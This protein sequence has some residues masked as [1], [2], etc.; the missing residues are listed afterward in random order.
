LRYYHY[1]RKEA[2]NGDVYIPP[3]NFKMAHE[4]EDSDFEDLEA[5]DESPGDESMYDLFSRLDISLSIKECYE[6][7][8]KFPAE[9]VSHLDNEEYFTSCANSAIELVKIGHHPCFLDLDRR[10]YLKTTWPLVFRLHNGSISGNS[11]HRLIVG[12]KGTGKSSFL[13][14]I[15][16]C[17]QKMLP[18]VVAVFLDFNDIIKSPNPQDA[19]GYIFD[20]L[21]ACHMID[22]SEAG[23]GTF[24]HLLELLLEKKIKVYL[25]V[26]EYHAVYAITDQWGKDF[27]LSIY[28]MVND[29]SGHFAVTVC[30]SSAYL[31]AL[32]FGKLN[33]S[34]ENFPAYIAGACSLNSSRTGVS[35]LGPIV[36][37]YEFRRYV[38][39][40]PSLCRHASGEKDVEVLFLL[41]G[42]VRRTVDNLASTPEGVWADEYRCCEEHKLCKTWGAVWL[43][44]IVQIRHKKHLQG[45]IAMTETNISPWEYMEWIDCDDI[46]SLIRSKEDPFSQFFKK[47]DVSGD[48]LD[49]GLV[50]VSDIDFSDLRRF[51]RG[52]DEGAFVFQLTKHGSR[53]RF[54]V[55]Y[56]FEFM[57]RRTWNS[58]VCPTWF[59]PYYQLCM[60]Y[61]Y[62]VLGIDAEA[63][64]AHCLAAQVYPLGYDTG[65]DIV[66]NINVS[67]IDSKKRDKIKAINVQWDTAIEKLTLAWID[68]F[69]QPAVFKEIP[70]WLGSDLVVVK[71]KLEDRYQV[72]LGKSPLLPRD[73]RDIMARFDSGIALK[74]T[75]YKRK[76]PKRF[77]KFLITSREMQISTEKNLTDGGVSV[78]KVYQLLVPELISWAR[79]LGLMHYL[80]TGD[81]LPPSV[82]PSMHV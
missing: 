33:G 7:A 2:T 66:G 15:C 43:A 71:D 59:T 79:S 34:V 19:S 49:N 81:V 51:F 76:T 64:I 4:N 23:D 9:I 37:R 60:S 62:G 73:A 20:A 40:Y 75:F 22:A 47:H 63:I 26:D 78:I 54:S 46:L 18:S 1:Q 72:K 29:R 8:E 5:G 39:Q 35:S 17:V 30:G 45:G 58:T 42:G 55:P 38:E 65:S 36:D 28:H 16:L 6:V 32:C 21:L 56:H 68:A 10:D 24:R 13:Q 48:K 41:T 12:P 14:A 11:H 77:R 44:M 25:T 61:P 50:D 70:D 74:M 80:P 27:M 57:Y 67:F 69:D 3:L 53:I 52:T 31:R 82:G